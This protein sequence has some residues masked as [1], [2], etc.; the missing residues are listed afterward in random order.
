MKHKLKR[1]DRKLSAP[2]G[3]IRP[4]VASLYAAATNDKKSIQATSTPSLFHE[5]D[6]QQE[7]DRKSIASSSSETIESDSS[8]SNAN[9]H[10]MGMPAYNKKPEPLILVSHDNVSVS[11]GVK[12]GVACLEHLDD[13][14]FDEEL[15]TPKALSSANRP[16]FLMP[17]I[18]DTQAY[19]PEIKGKV[20][21]A[22]ANGAGYLQIPSSVP[23][24]R[25]SWMSR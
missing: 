7:L 22:M 18:R 21:D 15:D 10:D 14:D 4:V 20:T 16:M 24:R 11:V 3:D 2:S 12:G 8:S 25:H 17:D 5:H 19:A 23:R 1:D 13:Y 6:E 9:H